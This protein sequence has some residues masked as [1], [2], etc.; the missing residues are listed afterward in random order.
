M[1]GACGHKDRA[2]RNA[3]SSIATS[4]AI[5]RP[6]VGFRSS[7]RL[8]EHYAK[9]GSEFGSV[10]RDEYLHLAQ[11][12][13]DRPVGGAVLEIVRTD[14]TVTRFDRDTGA[15]LA[16]ARD[17]TIRTFFSPN[18]GEQYFRRQARR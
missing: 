11:A 12:L 17:G 5:S 6:D 18:D 2:A 3:P 1:L 9:H 10:N 13:R 15:F 16:F 14:G 8:D 4:A 7:Q